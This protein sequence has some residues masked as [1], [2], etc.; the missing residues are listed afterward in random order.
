MH[1]GRAVLLH[2]ALMRTPWHVAFVLATAEVAKHVALTLAMMTGGAVAVALVLLL[3][4]VSAPLG[5]ALVSWFVWRSS[6]DGAHEVRRSMVLMR[7]RARA[8]GLRVVR[9]GAAGT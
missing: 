9:G 1:I 7:R 5:L 8:L 2:P 6:R 4:V 3:A